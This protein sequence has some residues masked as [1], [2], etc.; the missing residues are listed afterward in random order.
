MTAKEL[1]IQSLE[2]AAQ[3]NGPLWAGAYRQV[4]AVCSQYSNQPKT[5]K[6]ELRRLAKDCKHMA[7]SVVFQGAANQLEMNP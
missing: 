5:A 7:I 3:S 1:S 4:A 2:Q 6:R